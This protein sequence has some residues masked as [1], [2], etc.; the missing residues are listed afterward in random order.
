M[1]AKRILTAISAIFLSLSISSA[2]QH[3]GFIP[4]TVKWFEDLQ[5]ISAKYGIPS[6]VLIRVNSLKQPKVFT[7]SVIWIPVSDRYWNTVIDADTEV[8]QPQDNMA[9]NKGNEVTRGGDLTQGSDPLAD[10]ASTGETGSGKDAHMPGIV[11]AQPT[12]SV[13]CT[14]LL[15]FSGLNSNQTDRSLEFYAGVL[16]ASRKLAEE[17]IDVTLN[18][19]DFATRKNTSDWRNSD[20]ILGPIRREDLSEALPELSPSTIVISPLDQRAESLSENHPNLVQIPT[21]TSA[22]WKSIIGWIRDEYTEE[23]LDT[24]KLNYILIGSNL[25]KGTLEGAKAC[26]DSAGIP[27]R[28][29]M[30]DVQGA[31][32]GWSRAYEQY[33]LNKVIIAT[34]NEAVLNNTIRNMSVT[35]SLGNVTVFC[36]NKI[37]TYETI[38]L[39]DIHHARVHATCPYYIDYRDPGTIEFINTY[40][41]FFNAEPSQYAFQGYDLAYFLLKTRSKLGPAWKALVSE[42]D[43]KDLLQSSIKLVRNENGALYNTAVR[44]VLYEND[45]TL[46]LQ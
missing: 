31:V 23:Q 16:M 42:E 3:E 13:S 39:E 30:C 36:T 8:S 6:D 17:G 45:Y 43:T 9:N 20:F 29:C 33:K 28:L 32:N 26:L 27:Y 10:N 1:T 21:P 7:R 35:T 41:S 22:Q 25:D 37:R 38:P 34:G 15:P 4:H 19:V 14:V 46:I 5:S 24:A 12:N 40:R 44:R 11:T 18:A 2:Q